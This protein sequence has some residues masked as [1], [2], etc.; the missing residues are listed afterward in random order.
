MPIPT[1]RDE[2]AT[3]AA[4]VEWLGRTVEGARDVTVTDLAVP[5][6]SGFSNET[7]LCTAAWTGA[8]GEPV[9]EELV[10]R[11]KPTGYQVFLESDFEL[12]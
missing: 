1:Q 9:R 7:L 12:Q 2:A 5:D 8:D 3:T 4:L 10:V 11:V 6:G